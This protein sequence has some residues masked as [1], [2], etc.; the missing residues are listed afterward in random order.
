MIRNYL[1]VA[2]RNLIRNKTHSIINVAGLA[3]GIA[4]C[5][6]IFVL[7][8]FELSFDNFFPN[9]DRIYRVVTV[10]KN[11]DGVGYNGTVPFPVTG[12]LRA[13]F[14][15]IGKVAGIYGVSS[16]Q[17][18]VLGGQRDLEGSPFKEKTDVFF[19]EPEFFKIFGFGWLAGNPVASLAEPNSVVL[20]EDAAEKYFGSCQQALGKSIKYE[21]DEVLKVTGILRSIPP[22]SNFP[23]K[24]VISYKTFEHLNPEA[25]KDWISTYGGNY[26][27][28]SLANGSTESQVNGSLATL[29]KEHK[30]PEYVKDGLGLQPFDEMHFDSRFGTYTSTFSKG[31]LTS[32]TLIAAFLLIIACINFI[33]MSTAQAA[34]RSREVGVRKV[35][36]ANRRQLILQ[37]LGETSM[38]VILALI[39]ALGIAELLLPFVNR[40]L[41]VQLGIRFSDNP[42]FVGFLAAICGAVIFLSG[43]YPA[44][45]VSGFNVATT[46]KNSAFVKTIGGFS[47]RRILVVF[48][49]T[50]AQVLIIGMLVVVS[51]LEYFRNAPLGFTKDEIV[52]VPIPTD[53]LSLT[54]IDPLKNQLLAQSGIVDVSFSG[55]TPADN[56]HWSS[57]FTFDNLPKSTDFNA[58]LKW[59]D[60]DYFKIYNLQFVAGRP[61]R[62]SDTVREFVVNE[63]LLKKLGIQNPQDAIGKHISFWQNEINAPIVGVVKDFYNRPMSRPIDAT[64]LG[65]WKSVYALINIKIRPEQVK[66]T[67]SAIERLWNKTYPSYVYEYQFLDKKIDNFYKREDQLA[68]LFLVFAGVAIF[69]SC[70]GLYGLVSFMARQR[71]KEVGIR[72]V[73]GASV[74]SIIYLF[75][76]EFTILIGIAFLIA[77]PVAYYVMHLWLENFAFH[78]RLDIGLFVMAALGTL[79]VAWLTVGYRAIKAATANPVES[80]RYE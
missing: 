6:V 36:G 71:T 42:E 68:Q 31:L 2:L 73:L 67:L 21:N 76:R 52:T 20:T 77:T 38:I 49:F 22:N 39:V 12:G 41:R 34:D 47:L 4:V 14:P 78:I 18:T 48:Q 57:D 23:L 28:L 80:L 29:V 75:S 19:V 11:S 74:S 25:Y 40:L 32:V 55:F 53:S 7:V 79:M 37:S 30:P 1:Q 15:Q 9:R 27:F 61:Y 45:V 62:Q 5:I 17:I 43:I 54:Q 50:I 16:V 10:S 56:G 66:Q 70:L 64:V 69:V 60:A 72:K 13:E 51:Q 58:D 65:S 3:V 24:V 46:L 26:C 33:N 8:Q 44:L 63:T 59:A 35:L